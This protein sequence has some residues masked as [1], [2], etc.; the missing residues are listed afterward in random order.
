[1]YPEYFDISYDL[2]LC[3]LCTVLLIYQNVFMELE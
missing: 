2:P 1:M 3:V